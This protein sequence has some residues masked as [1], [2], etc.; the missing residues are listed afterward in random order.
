MNASFASQNRRRKL[1]RKVFEKISQN[2]G[3]GTSCKYPGKLQ[4][5]T[6]Q[7]YLKNDKNENNSP[8]NYRRWMHS[9]MNT[10]SS[11]S[12]R[13]LMR[14]SVFY[15]VLNAVSDGAFKRKCLMEN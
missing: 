3:M 8:Q 11:Q 10:C 6:L 13:Y 7:L 14:E 5:R 12:V 4:P 1:H 15:Q 9:L 2:E